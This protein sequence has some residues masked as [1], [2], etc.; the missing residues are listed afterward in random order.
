MAAKER[1]PAVRTQARPAGTMAAAVMVTTAAIRATEKGKGGGK[2]YG[3]LGGGK[4]GHGKNTGKRAQ[5]TGPYSAHSSRTRGA[6]AGHKDDPLPQPATQITPQTHT[7]AQDIRPKATEEGLTSPAQTP[8]TTSTHTTTSTTSSTAIQ[9]HVTAPQPIGNTD[10]AMTD[11][12]ETPCQ[13]DE[14]DLCEHKLCA[15]P[16]STSCSECNASLCAVHGQSSPC[17]SHNY[18]AQCLCPTC[19]LPPGLQGSRLLT[20]NDVT[21]AME[22]WTEGNL[23]QSSD[24]LTLIFHEVQKRASAVSTS[25]TTSS[26]NVLGQKS[27][28]RTYGLNLTKSLHASTGIRT[29]G[30]PAKCSTMRAV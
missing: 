8:L 10:L 17:H 6:K 7:M 5:E 22:L 19:N 28:S 23:L 15:S 29:D 16:A 14:G 30:S 13:H 25:S 3:L 1:I 20:D 18:L 21:S 12:E 27:S 26:K 24:P 11:S 4:G 9:G 2:G